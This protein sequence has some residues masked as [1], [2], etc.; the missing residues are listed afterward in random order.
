MAAERKILVVDDSIDN[1]DALRDLLRF[2]GYMVRD[3]S[4]GSE[5]LQIAADFK[6]D[7]FILDVMMPG[8][9][10]L[11]LL[12]LLNVASHGYE[13]IMMTGNESVDDAC[14]AI[15]YGALSYLR[16]PISHKELAE[17]V[18]KAFIKSSSTKRAC[19]VVSIWNKN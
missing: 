17:H 1:R 9:N 12:E 2:M 16:K 7:L 14:K 4:S 13:A 5:A 11:Q 18:E 8:M 19:S 10:G 3:A 6:P 15:E